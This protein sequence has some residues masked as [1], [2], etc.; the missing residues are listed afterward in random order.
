MACTIRVDAREPWPERPRLIRFDRSASPYLSQ[1]MLEINSMIGPRCALAAAI[2]GFGCAV[3]S[4]PPALAAAPAT[5][6]LETARQIVA[7]ATPVEFT[8]VRGGR[9]G[10]RGHG[11]RGFHGRRGGIRR[12]YGFRGRPGYGYRRHGNGAAIGAGIAGLAAGAIIG[13]ALSQAQAAPAGNA[14]AYCSQRFRS[15]DPAS[16]TYLGYDGVRHSCP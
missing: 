3:A 5:S 14:V 1:F 13:G 11:V 12:G 4:A 10:F 9:R 15:Y 7:G 6:S 16:G 8:R 2:F